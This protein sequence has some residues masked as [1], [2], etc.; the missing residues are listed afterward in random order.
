MGLVM[1]RAW[2]RQQRLIIPAVMSL[3]SDA[4]PLSSLPCACVSCPETEPGKQMDTAACCH[5]LDLHIGVWKIAS[6]LP[7]FSPLLQLA[8]PGLKLQNIINFPTAGRAVCSPRNDI[9]LLGT[10]ISWGYER[11]TGHWNGNFRHGTPV[12]QSELAQLVWA[13]G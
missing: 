3:L 8:L 4:Q 6:R 7:E 2:Y 13:C 12:T 9:R 11:T 5:L 10:F 1:I